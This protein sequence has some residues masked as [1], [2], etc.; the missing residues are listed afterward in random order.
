MIKKPPAAAMGSSNMKEQKTALWKKILAVIVAIFIA[1]AAFSAGW[2]TRTYTLGDKLVSYN[3]ALGIIKDNYYYDFDSD[4]AAENT[5]YSLAAMLDDYSEY[6]SAE[7]Y[8][9]LI[10]ENSGERSGIGVSY[11]FVSG[12]GMLLVSVL[13]NSPAYHAG[14]KTGMY[15]VSGSTADGNAVAFKNSDG[16]ASFINERET[17]EEFTLYCDDGEGYTLSKQFYMSSYVAMSTNSSSWSFATSGDES[18]LALYEDRQNVM[19]FLPDSAAYVSLSQFY[20]QAA[21][22]FG[23]LMGKFNEL[24]CDS[25]ILDLRNNGGGYVT[26]MQDIAGYFVN[27]SSAVAMTASYKS[28]KEEVYYCYS[29]KENLVPDG[30]K[31]YLLANSSTASAS[32]ALIGVLISYGLLDYEN[33]FISDYSDEFIE[34]WGASA[35]TGRT[36]GKGIMQST[37]VNPLTFEALKLTTAQIYWPNGKCIHGVGLTADDGCT[38]VGADWIV[39]YADEEL[40][41]VAEIIKQRQ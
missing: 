38:L 25:L 6:Y 31:I 11:S 23:V 20:G 5:L 10:R 33:V 28:G 17:G 29:H 21:A 3:W 39:T 7:E 24:G 40:Q 4:A 15:L 19:G 16:F 41:S 18:G 22:E 1:G 35:K 27:D 2:A 32:E 26:V 13:G 34:W 8:E 30:T 9:A 36:Y 14:L 37:F 12:K